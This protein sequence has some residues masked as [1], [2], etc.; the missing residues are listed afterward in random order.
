[1]TKSGSDNANSNC[2][3]RCGEVTVKLFSFWI[4]NRQR[5]FMK[6][7]KRINARMNSPDH[8]IQL[9]KIGNQDDQ[10][11]GVGASLDGIDLLYSLLVSSIA[12]NTP[13]SICRIEDDSS[14]LKA[15][16]RLLDDLL[17]GFPVHCDDNRII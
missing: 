11:L 10:R 6:M 12:A 15:I 1:M 4:N 14:L 16:N 5:P 2:T 13:D 9:I 3:I 7:Q 8:F 17:D